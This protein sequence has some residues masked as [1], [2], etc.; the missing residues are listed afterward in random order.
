MISH[1]EELCDS[2]ISPNNFLMII[3]NG[4]KWLWFVAC[5]GEEAEKFTQNC[6]VKN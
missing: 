3:L 1:K 4:T 5:A 6:G 2:Y